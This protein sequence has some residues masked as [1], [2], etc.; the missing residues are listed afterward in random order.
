MYESWVHADDDAGSKSFA[1]KF[2]ETLMRN[3]TQLWVFFLGVWRTYLIT[4]GDISRVDVPLPKGI[5]N[6]M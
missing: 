2:A 5:N 6:I 1:F 4:S 3:I